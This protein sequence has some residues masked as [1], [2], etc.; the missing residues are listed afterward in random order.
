MSSVYSENRLTIFG[1]SSWT[2]AGLVCTIKTVKDIHS[3]PGGDTRQTRSNLMKTVTLDQFEI[4]AKSDK[5]QRERVLDVYEHIY[6]EKHIDDDEY[7]HTA[8][9]L[10][11]FGYAAMTS[12]LDGIEITYAENY[13]YDNHDEESFC[14]SADGQEEIWEV[15]GVRVVDEDGDEVDVWELADYL[16]KAFYEIN[17]DFDKDFDFN[18]TTD[19]G[20][21]EDSKM[22]TITLAVDNEPNIRFT[23]ECIAAVESSDDR[24]GRWTELKLFKT[25]SDKYVC[26]QVGVTCYQGER[27]RYSGVVCETTEEVIEFFGH[28][29]L[30]KE[31]YEDAGIDDAVNVE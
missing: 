30:A 3:R 4:L 12:I 18:E 23:G 26:Q 2:K 8:N 28:R 29:W 22:E 21:G 20:I 5:W 17:Y 24:P 31:L 27:N 25:S 16:P 9:V 11:T 14:V 19:I 13:S 1:P 10:C 15:E 7:P 6:R